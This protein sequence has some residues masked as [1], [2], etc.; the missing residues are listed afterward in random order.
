MSFW[1]SV[2]DITSMC[3]AYDREDGSDVRSSDWLEQLI[4]ID[5]YYYYYLCFSQ[6]AS[7]FTFMRSEQELMMLWRR[8]KSFRN[9][10][11][12]AWGIMVL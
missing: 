3:T 1:R 9:S 12:C 7:Y 10:E 2:A 11:L 8:N 4:I 6:T 5:N